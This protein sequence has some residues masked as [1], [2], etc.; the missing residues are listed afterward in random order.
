[1]ISL[2]CI[3]FNEKREMTVSMNELVASFRKIAED[4]ERQARSRGIDRTTQADLIDAAAKCHWL[5]GEA[6]ALCSKLEQIPTACER[7]LEKCP[8]PAR[9]PLVSEAGRAPRTASLNFGDLR[10]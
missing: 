4:A 10:S 9:K 7:C 1:V 3:L 6:S 8:Q 5:A 2:R